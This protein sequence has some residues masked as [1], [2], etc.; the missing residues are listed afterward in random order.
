MKVCES[1]RMAYS[2]IDAVVAQDVAVV[3]DAL[4]DTSR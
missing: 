4:D 2:S 1:R 3:P